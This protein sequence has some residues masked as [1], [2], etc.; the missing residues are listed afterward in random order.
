M[1][2]SVWKRA[3]VGSKSSNDRKTST[4]LRNV[5]ILCVRVRRPQS[6]VGLQRGPLA[7]EGELERQQEPS[8]LSHEEFQ[9]KRYQSPSLEV[10]LT[11]PTTLH[12]MYLRGQMG[13]V[14]SLMFSWLPV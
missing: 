3:Q 7:G 13:Y 11:Q 2:S 1:P 5:H 12:L 6:L 8:G 14:R 4:V 9:K 10:A